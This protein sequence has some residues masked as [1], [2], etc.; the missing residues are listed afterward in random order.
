VAQTVAAMITL[1]ALQATLPPALE[2]TATETVTPTFTFTPEP[3]TLTPTITLTPTPPFTPT[4]EISLI[5]VS[6]DTNCRSG[7]GKVYDMQGALLVGEFAQIYA[8]DPTNNYWYIRNP[9]GDPE[10]CWVWGKYAT[11]IGPAL[12]LPV[13]TPPPTPTATA[14]PLP[15][16]KFTAQYTGLDSCNGYW[17]TEIRLKNT[18]GV[19][20]K[21]VGIS[22][23]DKVTDAT[24]AEISD[25]FINLDNC[26]T[27]STK[28][29]LG[30]GETYIIST[31]AF[32]Y[33]PEGHKLLMTITLCSDTGQ[34][35][36]CATEKLNFAP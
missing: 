34:T 23:K 30:V 25:G 33:N 32:N 24:V 1:D 17:W 9:D 14:T 3:P 2:A 26:Q 5:T 20:F 8:R 16:P 10:F 13:F 29:I 35:G 22:I 6:V 31:P 11:L 27:K 12:L 7:P 15:A 28:E 21:S 4:L 18:G 19:P 36:T